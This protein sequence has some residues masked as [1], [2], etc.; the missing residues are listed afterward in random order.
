MCFWCNVVRKIRGKFSSG[1]RY[2]QYFLSFVGCAVGACW[3]VC[4][5]QRA[6]SECQPFPATVW[7]LGSKLRSAGLATRAS[8]WIC[9]RPCKFRVC[10]EAYMIQNYD[11]LEVALKERMRGCQWV[12]GKMPSVISHQEIANEWATSTHLGW[13]NFAWT[14]NTRL[15]QHKEFNVAM[16]EQRGGN[17]GHSMGVEK[18]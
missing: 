15:V 16:V 7:Y 14:D 1:R 2:S 12:H 17:D 11:S 4:G 3:G 9:Q 13:P 5:G 8:R 18:Y 6:V 10:K